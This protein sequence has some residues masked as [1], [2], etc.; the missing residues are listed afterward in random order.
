MNIQEKLGE[1][2]KDLKLGLIVLA[3]CFDVRSAK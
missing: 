3:I 2:K 1:H